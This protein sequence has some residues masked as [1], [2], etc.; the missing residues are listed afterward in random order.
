MTMTQYNYFYLD[1]MVFLSV[2][3]RNGNAV[4]PNAGLVESQMVSAA[5]SAKVGI[6]QINAVYSTPRCIKVFF[7]L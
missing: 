6:S 7:L 5:V 1:R 3:N 4:T 2:T